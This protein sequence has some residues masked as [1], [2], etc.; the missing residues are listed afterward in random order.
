MAAPL[1]IKKISVLR[2]RF[3]LGPSLLGQDLWPSWMDAAL[4]LKQKIITDSTYQLVGDKVVLRVNEDSKSAQVL[5][6]VLGI[7]QLGLRHL[8]QGPSEILIYEFP[9]TIFDLDFAAIVDRAMAL[10][11]KIAHDLEEGYDIVFEGRN[12]A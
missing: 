5:L 11:T 10:R 2:K 8:D 12:L 1:K 7:P 9:E 3:I 6:E 4:D